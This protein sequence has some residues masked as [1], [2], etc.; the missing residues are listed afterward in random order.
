MQIIPK[1][2]SNQFV[3]SDKDKN[4][5][6]LLSSLHHM[7]DDFGESNTDKS[8]YRPDVSAVRS[9]IGTRSART[10]C[11]DYPDGVDRGD[12]LMVILR[13]KGLD[14]TEIDALAER[15]ENDVE[16]KKKLD[17]DKNLQEIS[18][19]NNDELLDYVRKL[20]ESLTSDDSSAP[21]EK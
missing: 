10:G 15:I 6:D 19:K 2:Y 18:K 13:N 1:T 7:T 9:Q 16:L 17:D 20:S 14:P 11:F 12:N 21:S 3:L 4:V 5:K 8:F